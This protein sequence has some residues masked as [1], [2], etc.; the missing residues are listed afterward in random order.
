VQ[1]LLGSRCGSAVKVMEWENKINQNI[2]GSL[3]SPARATFKRHFFKPMVLFLWMNCCILSLRCQFI[4]WSLFPNV[5][6]TNKI[7]IINNMRKTLAKMSALWDS[8]VQSPSF[9]NVVIAYICICIAYIACMLFLLPSM[10]TQC[11]HK[12]TRGS[13][14]WH[15]VLC[16]ELPTLRQYVNAWVL[17]LLC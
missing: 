12:S 4:H 16:R 10:L 7:G 1:E 2:P 11:W 5:L 6:Y 14:K 13:Q 17:L 3:P 15:F 8:N 9:E